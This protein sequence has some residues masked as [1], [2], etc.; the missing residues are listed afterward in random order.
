[1]VEIQHMGNIHHRFPS[2]GIAPGQFDQ[3]IDLDG[4]E[5]WNPGTQTP[6]LIR[7]I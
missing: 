3:E 2:K 4:E 6:Y 1:M 7:G 5:I